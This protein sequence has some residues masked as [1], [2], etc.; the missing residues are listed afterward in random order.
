LLGSVIPVH[1]EATLARDQAR[2]EAVVTTLGRH[3]AVVLRGN[4]ALTVS[5]QG[6]DEAVAAMWVLEAAARVRVA[7]IGAPNA[8]RLTADEVTSWE[9]LA[10]EL[11]GRIW[12]YLASRHLPD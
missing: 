11:L 9:G 6:L 2:A 5:V 3:R 10:P 12:S 7:L 4:G 1:N 8:Q